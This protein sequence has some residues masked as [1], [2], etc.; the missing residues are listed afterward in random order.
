MALL[1]ISGDILETSSSIKIA[2]I[3]AI[4]V[5]EAGSVAVVF[6]ANEQAF[7]TFSVTDFISFVL[8]GNSALCQSRGN[9][10]QG[11]KFSDFDNA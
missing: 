2:M 8:V 11:L 7:S 3:L 9:S 4:S 10:S 5:G 1:T 6:V